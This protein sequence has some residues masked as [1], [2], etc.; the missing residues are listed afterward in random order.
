MLN[1]LHSCT[2]C[3]YNKTENLSPHAFDRFDYIVLGSNT[4]MCMILLRKGILLHTKILCSA[5]LPKDQLQKHQKFPY[6]Q[7]SM[8]FKEKVVVLKKRIP[9]IRRR[10][11]I[12]ICFSKKKKLFPKMANCD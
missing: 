1:N 4:A 10:K 2:A 11:I 7:P 9:I 5:C 3:R 8:N 12:N 6:Y